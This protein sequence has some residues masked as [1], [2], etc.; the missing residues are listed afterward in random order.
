MKIVKRYFGIQRRTLTAIGIDVNAFLPNGPER[1]AKHPLLLLVIT[2]MPVLQYISIGHYAYKNSNNMVTATYSFSLS[3]QGVICLTKI[4]IF[5]FKRRDIVKLVK[6]LQEDVFNAKSDEL[7]ITKEENS[8]DVLHCTVYGSAVYLWDYSHL[9]GYSLVYIWNMMR[10]YTLA[11][12]SVAIDSLFSWLVCNIVAHFRILM[13]RFQRAA[14]L[15]PGLDRPEV[16]VSR[17]QERLIFDCVRFHNRTLNLVQELNLVYGGIIFVKF[18]VSSVQICC[19]AFFLNS[20]GASQSMAKLMY[21][22]LLLSAVALQLMLYCYNGQRITDV[23]FQVATKVYS[24]FPWS[25]MP[26]STKRMLLPPMIRAQRFSELRG[27]FFTVDLSLYLWV[28][29]TAGSLIAALK[30]LEEDK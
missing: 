10:M 24:T 21:Q 29:K 15:T 17:E 27:V 26:A 13:L 25:K 6:M 11:F 2:V 7:V 23:S 8:R 9:P 16:S 20:F 5:L 18:V 12:A 30:T 14:W 22:F 19:S 3:C 1:I 28:F 4:L